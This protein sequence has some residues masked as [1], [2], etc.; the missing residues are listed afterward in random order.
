MGR[1]PVKTADAHTGFAVTKPK[2][3]ASFEIAPNPRI[4]WL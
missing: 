1:L 4:C 3:L 2:I